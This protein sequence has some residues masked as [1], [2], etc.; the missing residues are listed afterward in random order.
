MTGTLWLA[1]ATAVPSSHDGGSMTGNDAYFVWHTYEAGYTLSAVDGARRLIT[2]GNEV[3]LCFNPITG[4]IAQ[5]L[6]A[7]RAARGLMN[8]AGGVETNRQGRVCLQVEVVAYAARPWMNDLTAAGKV[9]LHKILAWADAWGVPRTYPNGPVGPVDYAASTKRARSVTAWNGPGGHFCHADVP[10][11][12][13]WDHGANDLRRLFTLGAVTPPPV[14]V[15]PPTTTA[16]V[17]PTTKGAGMQD[18]LVKTPTASAVWLSN[19]INRRWVRTPAELAKV[20]ARMK[21]A[22]QSAAVIVDSPLD[23]YGL[24]VGPVPA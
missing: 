13:H 16:V 1:G 22:G 23:A 2:A 8:A 10:E 7:N 6:P 20:Q 3:H 4:A 14:V 9:G 19:G 15:A 17:Y 24:P 21:A 18:V 12:D 11:N 5:M